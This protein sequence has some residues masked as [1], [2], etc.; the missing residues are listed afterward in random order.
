M[1]TIFNKEDNDWDHIWLCGPYLTRRLFLTVRTMFDSE[2]HVDSDHYVW[3]RG[4][5]L[6]VSQKSWR[7]MSSSWC[8]PSKEDK[9]LFNM[10]CVWCQWTNLR[11]LHIDHVCCHFLCSI[12][13]VVVVVVVKWNYSESLKNTYNWYFVELQGYFLAGEVW[14][15]VLCSCRFDWL[16]CK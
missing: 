5:L 10:F 9:S 16:G 2:D 12:F 7:K 8:M 11:P 13:V 6:T 4:T 3:H 14:W 15:W 1:R